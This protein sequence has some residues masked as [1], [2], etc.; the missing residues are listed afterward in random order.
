MQRGILDVVLDQIIPADPKRHK[1]SAA[2]VGVLAYIHLRHPAALASIAQQLTELDAYA[3][4][5]Y[6]QP[7]LSLP[8]ASQEEAT[9]SLRLQNPQ[10]L[11]SLA[12]YTVACYYIN[13]QVMQAI[14]LPPRA[15]YP[16]GFTVHRGDLTLL[17]PVRERGPIWRRAN[18]KQTTGN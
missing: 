6:N 8:R 10:F 1:P 15:P 18:I 4:A 11:R 14:G 12:L 5:R 3:E 16:E 7:F 9:Q 13:D 2:E 17:D